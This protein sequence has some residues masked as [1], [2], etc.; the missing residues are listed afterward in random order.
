MKAKIN[1]RIKKSNDL[2]RERKFITIGVFVSAIMVALSIFV[3]VYFN[4]EAVAER[5]FEFLVRE[6]YENYY[7]DKFMKEL[8][9]DTREKTLETF[10]TTGFS[11]VLLRQLLLY[12]NKKYANFEQY[13]TGDYSCDK[14][15][16]S[17]KIYPVAPYSKTDYTVELNLVCE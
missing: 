11:P 2:A 10:S 6:Y 17:A 14:N 4:P 12:N 9:E 1:S 3:T 16:T 15:K 5:K 8:S 7:Y 13:F